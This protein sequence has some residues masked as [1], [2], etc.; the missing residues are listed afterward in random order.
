LQVSSPNA[1]AVPGASP[2]EVAD[3][4]LDLQMFDSQPLTRS[5]SGL[6]LEY[7]IVQLYSRDAGRREARIGF[8]VGQ[9]TQDLGFRN[10]VDV[11]FQCVPA[12]GVV[13]AVKDEHGQPTTASFLIRRPSGWRRISRSIRR[14]TGATANRCPCPTAPT[15]WRS[16]A[17]RS[18]C[19]RAAR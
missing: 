11:L 5:L 14:S 12:R 15:P 1:A 2:A 8:N 19:R 16:S 7:R 3:R 17:G 4:W 6:S 13:L 10:E 9:G 18:R